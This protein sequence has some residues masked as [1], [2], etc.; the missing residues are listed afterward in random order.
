M[1]PG[2]NKKKFRILDSKYNGVLL[3]TNVILDA[4]FNKDSEALVA[5]Q[6]LNKMGLKIYYSTSTL[7]EVKHIII[8]EVDK[9]NLKYNPLLFVNKLFQ[10]FGIKNIECGVEN[11]FKFINNS[12]KP[13]VSSALEN[14]LLLI[15][16]DCRLYHECQ[17]ENIEVSL[18][19][20]VRNEWCLRNN[21]LSG[22]LIIPFPLGSDSGFIFSRV[23]PDNWESSSIKS[24][25]HTVVDF[26]YF[27][28]LEY[29]SADN[30]WVF[31]FKNS[32]SLITS[33]DFKSTD[34][35]NFMIVYDFKKGRALFMNSHSPNSE[36]VQINNFD[37]SKG[38]GQIRIGSSNN[39]DNYL[40]G[41]LGNLSFGAGKISR[42]KFNLFVKY[43]E[44]LPNPS[45]TDRLRLYLSRS[46]CTSDGEFFIYYKNG[47]K[48]DVIGL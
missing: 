20:L 15:T 29:R 45:D 17:Q 48:N 16:S 11:D 30:V 33:F 32:K 5:I 8:K 38:V 23:I 12:D 9:Q 6:L 47:I 35:I 43:P 24:G 44:L 22:R 28:K 36:S 1:F 42:Q 26:E 13:I 3:D 14:D 25:I 34:V 37:K 4:A 40:N 7:A 39:N 31:Q 27:G 2:S 46:S 19:W 10:T 18:T 41:V 21:S